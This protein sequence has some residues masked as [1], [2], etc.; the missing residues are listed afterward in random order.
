MSFLKNGIQF[1][2]N[3]LKKKYSAKHL[4]LSILSSN[5]I[6]FSLMPGEAQTIAPLKLPD[7]YVVIKISAQLNTVFETGKEVTLI[8][9]KDRWHTNAIL[10][11]ELS[12]QADIFQ[13]DGVPSFEIAVNGNETQRIIQGQMAIYPKFNY[14]VRREK[15]MPIRD[16]SF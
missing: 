8:S 16:A 13:S 3:L 12:Y 15:T 11:K 4:L 1:R 5:L 14:G 10:I 6:F 7:H 9:R 2:E